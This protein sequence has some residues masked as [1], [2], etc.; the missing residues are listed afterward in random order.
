M[1]MVRIVP[2]QNVEKFLNSFFFHTLSP[3]KMESVVSFSVLGGERIFLLET[4]RFE[5]RHNIYSKIIMLYHQSEKEYNG[6][7]ILFGNMYSCSQSWHTYIKK[8]REIKANPLV[9]NL[10]LNFSMALCVFFVWENDRNL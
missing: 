1:Y 2:P 6:R 3:K 5:L 10:N 8:A 9:L 4:I 7:N